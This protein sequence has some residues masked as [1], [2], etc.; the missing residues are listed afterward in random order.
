GDLGSPD[1]AR[2]IE[3]RAGAHQR[4]SAHQRQLMIFQQ[5]QAHPI[6]ERE[7]GRLRNGDLAQRRELQ[8]VPGREGGGAANLGLVRRGGGGTFAGRRLFRRRVLHGVVLSGERSAAQQRQKVTSR[9]F[10]PPLSAAAAG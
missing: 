2:G 10:A 6:G 8:R 1:L 9:H 3:Q 5:V 7:L 4:E